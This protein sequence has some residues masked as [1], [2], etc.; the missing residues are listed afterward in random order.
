MVVKMP[1]GSR[2]VHGARCSLRVPTG[3][4]L[5]FLPFTSTS[6]PPSAKTL[7]LLKLSLHTLTDC[8]TNT[9]LPEH[10][11]TKVELNKPYL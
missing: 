5:V 1:L 7:L 11:L 2:N 8:S 6:S 9:I 3:Q 10:S 4:Y